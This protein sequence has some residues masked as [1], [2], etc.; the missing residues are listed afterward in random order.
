MLMPI[1]GQ[2]V[3]SYLTYDFVQILSD[4][5]KGI[6]LS[7]CIDHKSQRV[8]KASSLFCMSLSICVVPVLVWNPPRD[9]C[10][11]HTVCNMSIQYAFWVLA[12]NE[13][14]STRLRP[15]H[16]DRL[17]H[18]PVTLFVMSWHLVPVTQ[19]QFIVPCQCLQS[20]MEIPLCYLR[21]KAVSCDLPVI[22]VHCQSSHRWLSLCSPFLHSSTCIQSE[23]LL[24]LEIQ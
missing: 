13:C 22:S 9:R 24:L 10:S 17:P 2:A 11:C 3:S 4:H 14:L 8:L 21:V 15:W 1:K 6:C 23:Q 18:S 16:T 12:Q 5:S 19:C 20:L 7:L